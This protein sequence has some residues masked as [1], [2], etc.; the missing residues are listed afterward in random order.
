M[1]FFVFLLVVAAR[2]VVGLSMKAFRVNEF[3]GV[4]TEVKMFAEIRK[5][6]LDET[7][8]SEVVLMD[9]A[10]GLQNNVE[11]FFGVQLGFAGNVFYCFR[12]RFSDDCFDMFGRNVRVGCFWCRHSFPA[13]R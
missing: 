8:D 6:L 11:L 7:C 5:I 3:D 1:D 4:A 13:I 12:R 9:T 2:K 10:S